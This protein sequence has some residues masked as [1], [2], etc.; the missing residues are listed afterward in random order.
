MC[1]P[2]AIG[3]AAGGLAVGEAVMTHIGTNQ[4]YKANK[5]AANFNYAN[6]LTT[7]GQKQVELDQEGSENAFDTAIATAREQG[8][9]TASASDQG[10][11]S[12]SIISSINAGMFGIGRQAEVE[13]INDQNSRIQLGQERTGADIRRQSQ[14]NSKPRSSGL[15][16]ALGVGKGVMSGVQAGNAA[17][18]KK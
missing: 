15:Q 6:D 18:G 1:G 12:S 8:R 3:A 7:L 14:I 13:R 17:A 9:I 2:A 10:L 11:A 4:A 16:L 5:K